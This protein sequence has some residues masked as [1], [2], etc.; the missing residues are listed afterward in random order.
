MADQT[1][2][3]YITVTAWNMCVSTINCLMYGVFC[4]INKRSKPAGRGPGG[5]L[6]S[7]HDLRH[8]DLLVSAAPGRVA[9]GRAAR[10]VADLCHQAGGKTCR[11]AAGVSFSARVCTIPWQACPSIPR[12]NLLVFMASFSKHPSIQP[13]RAHGATSECLKRITSHPI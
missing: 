8:A 7:E 4:L 9:A 3:N 1:Y 2:V 5:G 13:T 11:K 12:F 6:P 10:C